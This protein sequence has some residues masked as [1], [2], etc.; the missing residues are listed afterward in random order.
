[1]GPDDGPSRE[2]IPS[3]LPNDVFPFEMFEAAVQS[4]IIHGVVVTLC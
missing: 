1:M 3:N 4:D 2:H